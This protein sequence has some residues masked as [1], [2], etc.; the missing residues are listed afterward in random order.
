MALSPEEEAELQQ[1]QAE[2]ETLC[3]IEELDDEQQARFDATTERIDE[4]ED[5]E[6]EWTAETLAIT[7]AV[8]T[9][10]HDGK[11]A[12]HCGLVRPEDAPNTRAKR[13]KQTQDGASPLSAALIESLTAHRSAA[14]TAA[15]AENTD[16]ALAATVHAMAL[17]VFYHTGDTAL[18]VTASP[19]YLRGIEGTRAQD[20]VE[21]LREQ[22]GEHI[23]GSA[24]DLFAW[25]LAQPQDRLLQL[26]AFCAAQTVNAVLPKNERA[27]T[28][29]MEHAALLADALMLDMAA[30]FTPTAAN[31]FGKVSKAQIIADL[32][33]IKGDIAPAWSAMKKVDLA[34]LA[35][36][37][38]E[39]TGWLPAPLR[40]A[41]P[42]A[43]AQ[44]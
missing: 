38:T 13:K 37:E 33:E 12:F 14:L 31:Y 5:R 17:R 15:L 11:P 35:E 41:V 9:L 22:W 44:E 30:W 16:V 25:C 1:L 4:L 6:T 3:E 2:V 29:R 19:V 27:A 10:G 24:E 34:A 43:E 21:S 7:G 36:R 20:A 23:P 42:S 8:V 28:S 40:A 32:R 39:G 18:Q 26:L